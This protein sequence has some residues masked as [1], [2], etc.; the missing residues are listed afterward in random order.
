VVR[1]SGLLKTRSKIHASTTPS[2]Y[3]IPGSTAA[4][5]ASC[6]AAYQLSAPAQSFAPGF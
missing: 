3:V 5:S 6:C 2:R 1:L 4:R